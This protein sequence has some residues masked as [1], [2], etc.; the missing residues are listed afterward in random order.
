MEDEDEFDEHLSSSSHHS[1]P[2]PSTS[3][4][5]AIPAEDPEPLVP[6]QPQ[7]RFSFTST[8]LE[9][10]S[11]F[12]P[13]ERHHYNMTPLCARHQNLSYVN[14][15]T[16]RS[17]ESDYREVKRIYETFLKEL[18][19]DFHESFCKNI[20]H[21]IN[22]FTPTCMDYCKRERSIFCF[23]AY[24]I[25]KI[26]DSHNEEERKAIFSQKI[27]YSSILCLSANLFNFAYC[28]LQSSYREYCHVFGIELIE[29]LIPINW[30]G[31]NAD[32]PKNIEGYLYDL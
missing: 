19:E 22:E 14:K 3:M 27:S 28:S 20:T 7:R 23:F 25:Q 29:G 8:K 30:F 12:R 26:H 16:L 13:L 31:L 21:A 9:P 10:L 32:M 24:F 4:I 17:Y 6:E 18:Y 15:I 1:Q 2:G 11:P 5:D